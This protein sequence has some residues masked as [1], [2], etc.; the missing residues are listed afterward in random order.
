MGKDDRVSDKTSIYGIGKDDRVSDKM[1]EL[2][3]EYKMMNVFKWCDES[4]NLLWLAL[5][6]SRWIA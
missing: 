2:L 4:V 5:D 1:V 3:C 6:I